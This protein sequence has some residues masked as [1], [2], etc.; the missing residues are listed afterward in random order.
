MTDISPADRQA[1]IDRFV[2]ARLECNRIMKDAARIEG[3]PEVFA[4]QG[5][6]IAALAGLKLYRIYGQPGAADFL[7]LRDDLEEVARKVDPLIEAIGREAK[8]ADQKIDLDHFQGQL[9]AALDGNATSVLDDAAERV[10]ADRRD[11]A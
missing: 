5:E 2:R 8:G 3:L 7:A 6:T 11:A 1:A 4:A 10:E 9:T